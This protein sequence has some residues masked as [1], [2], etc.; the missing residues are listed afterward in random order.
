MASLCFL[1]QYH[2]CSQSG[3][4]HSLLRFCNIFLCDVFLHR[5]TIEVNGIL[6]VL[7]RA[8]KVDTEKLA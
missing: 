6:F 4:S 3:V 7:P 5:N 1:P 8:L 2:P